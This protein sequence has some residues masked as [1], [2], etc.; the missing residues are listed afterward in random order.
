MS[1]PRERGKVPMEDA[2]PS[3]IRIPLG[4]A[5]AEAPKILRQRLEVL[6][7]RLLEV[8]RSDETWEVYL[9]TVRTMVAVIKALEVASLVI[10]RARDQGALFVG[11]PP[12]SPWG[13][14]PR[15]EAVKLIP[16]H[17]GERGAD[18]PS[19]SFFLAPGCVYAP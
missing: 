16:G 8:P 4:S 2:I 17:L 18:I 10:L 3:E 11:P 14:C 13:R 12:K 1:A 15:V 19:G 6:S 7:L 5:F 9:R